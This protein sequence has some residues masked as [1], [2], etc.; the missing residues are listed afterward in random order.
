MQPKDNF[1][2]YDL[3]SL[4]NKPV[5][6]EQHNLPVIDEIDTKVYDLFAQINEVITDSNF[7]QEL[8]AE[9]QEEVSKVLILLSDIKTLYLSGK[10]IK[11]IHQKSE[12][13]NLVFNLSIAIQYFQHNPEKRLIEKLRIDGEFRIRRIKNFWLALPINFYRRV[14]SKII[15]KILLGLILGLPLYIVLPLGLSSG[16]DNLEKAL[17]SKG[18]LSFNAD[19]RS[20]ETPDM[21]IKD[22]QM[23]VWLGNL[24]FTTGA[25]GSIVSILSRLSN[26]EQSEDDHQYEDSIIPILVGFYKPL[27]GGTFGILIFAIL[28]GGIIPISFGEINNEKRQD[29][30]WMSL[31]SLSFVVGFSERLAKDII[32]TTEKNF[33]SEK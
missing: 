18:I 24:C 25:L 10:L 16:S 14:T 12:V 31:F 3:N 28:Q 13:A 21:Y 9:N 33:D 1:D 17:Q 29:Q 4:E 15:L 23:T 22:F 20:H 2:N 32:N 26:Y 27:I 5:F 19:S 30:R 11:N 7:I 6:E 8:S